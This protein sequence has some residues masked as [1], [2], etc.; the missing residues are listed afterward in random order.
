MLFEQINSLVRDSRKAMSN[1]LYTRVVNLYAGYLKEQYKDY[2]YVEVSIRDLLDKDDKLIITFIENKLY[3]LF[4]AYTSFNMCLGCFVAF[5]KYLNKRSL[6]SSDFLEKVIK[7]ISSYKKKPEKLEKDERYLHISSLHAVVK[8]SGAWF[9]YAGKFRP[10]KNDPLRFKMLLYFVYYTGIKRIELEKIK[11]SDF[12]LEECSVKII[13]RK[14]YYPPKVRDMIIDYFNSDEEVKNAFNF[15]NAVAGRINR[16]L[17]RYRYLGHRLT[18][19]F[20]RD[21]NANMIMHK[22]KNVGVLMKLHGEI[23]KCYIKKYELKDEEVDKIYKRS[24]HYQE[25]SRGC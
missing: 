24:V 17:S 19:S 6:V 25:R 8:R 3:N 5:Y 7:L 14:C 11:R 10:D 23:S 21:S 18:L 22:T 16:I 1:R 4:K 2:L 9:N 12:N 20:L 15:T 13:N